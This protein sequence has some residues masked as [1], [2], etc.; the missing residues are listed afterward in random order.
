MSFS[1]LTRG[2]PLTQRGG[3]NAA[4]KYH[5]DDI[6]IWL[7]QEWQSLVP[8]NVGNQP[9]TSPGQWIQWVFAAQTSGLPPGW[10]NVAAAPYNA[11]PTGAT[12]STS[13]FNALSTYLKTHGGVFYIPPGNYTISGV[14]NNDQN[15]VPYTIMGAGGTKDAPL[16]STVNFTGTGAVN[17]MTMNSTGGVEVC[18]VYFTYTALTGNV[19]SADGSIHGVDSQDCNIHHCGFGGPT[20]PTANALL[21]INE[22]D[23]WTIEKNL[24][25]KG[26]NGLQMGPNYVN[27]CAVL[28]NVF[29][30]CTTSFI[31]WNS[32]DSE[33]CTIEG[34]TFE[35]GTCPVAIQGS[36]TVF[37]GGGAALVGPQ[38][39][40][41]WFGDVGTATIWI[42][43]LAV[44]SNNKVGTIQGNY[45]GPISG[46]DCS[47]FLRGPWVSIG[48]V[49]DG[50]PAFDTD[51]YAKFAL[52]TIGDNA[53]TSGMFPGASRP[54]LSGLPLMSYIALSLNG[55]YGSSQLPYTPPPQGSSSNSSPNTVQNNGVNVPGSVVI[56]TSGSAKTI[57]FHAQADGAQ[58][59]YPIGT[60][61]FFIIAGAGGATFSPASGGVT[62]NGTLAWATGTMARATQVAQDV[63][64][65][66]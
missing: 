60:Q 35:G 22:C 31:Y 28:R 11:D 64:W 46:G 40:G 10:I 25:E 30:F 54:N 12:D 21:M 50:T 19:V 37:T 53:G 8:N 39:K 15:T 58:Y 45:F 56:Y 9:D 63:W 4:Q 13:A 62:L 52:I 17:G 18:H 33:A 36:A 61:L 44:W 23:N 14:W 26:I 32:N 34:N 43:Q 29:A 48:N 47:C 66:L 3:W 27:V 5:I 20:I 1:V 59:V 16:A 38:I 51:N 42:N 24:F 7:G 41:N 49:F 57:T 2:A 55:V 65:I 6:V